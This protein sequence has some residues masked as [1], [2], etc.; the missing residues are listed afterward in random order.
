MR[1]LLPVG[2]ISTPWMIVIAI[3][4]LAIASAISARTAYKYAYNAQQKEIDRIVNERQQERAAWNAQ[5]ASASINAWKATEEAKAKQL[6]IFVT[7]REIITRWKTEYV[8]D[9]NCGL[10]LPAVRAVNQMLEVQ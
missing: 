8:P 9:P 5:L 2:G 10:S 4:V 3:V 6:Q 7:R 1:K